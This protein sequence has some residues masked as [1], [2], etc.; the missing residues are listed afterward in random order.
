MPGPA[1]GE[2]KVPFRN[3]KEEIRVGFGVQGSEGG[4]GGREKPGARGQRQDIV[5]RNV[6]LMSL[7]HLGAVYS[8]VLIPKA[9]PLTLLWAYF[10]F[11]LTALGV[12]A[13]A[14]R[15]WSHRSYKAKLPLRIFLAAANSMAFQVASQPESCLQT[16][17]NFL[18]VKYG[19]RTTSSSGPGT[20]ESTTS[21]RRR[22]LI[23]TTPAGASSSPISGG[24][25]SAS[26]G[27]LSRR[28]GSLT[29]P[30]C[31]LIL[32]SGSRESSGNSRGF[33]VFPP[34]ASVG[35]TIGSSLCSSIQ[36]FQVDT[37]SINSQ[38]F[39]VDVLNLQLN[40]L[41]ILIFHH[42][43]KRGKSAKFRK[44][45]RNS[46]AVQTHK[47]SHGSDSVVSPSIFYVYI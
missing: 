17:C 14:H 30:T 19:P 33:P 40:D 5:W 42:E 15:L 2:G 47:H 11:L 27:M 46:C 22:T 16:S 20:T 44:V 45:E 4:G 3:A 9:Q 43:S 34:P 36:L 41:L 26:I 28:G 35:F 39:I 25:L 1:A 37:T 38:N 7:L 13:G 31:W 18:L 12:T 29:S 10:C 24:C 32:W 21:T 8:L 6:F 23:P